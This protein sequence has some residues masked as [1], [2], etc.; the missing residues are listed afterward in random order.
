MT[1]TTRNSTRKAKTA[2]KGSK[3]PSVASK[4]APASKTTPKASGADTS[5]TVMKK[6]FCGVKGRSGAPRKNRN[7]IRHG[8]HAGQLPP[9][10]KYIEVRLNTFRRTVED[11]VLAVKGEIGITDAS[12]INTAVKWE[13]HG[14]LAQRWLRLEGDSLKPADRLNFSREIARASAERDRALSQLGL[15]EKPQLTLDTYLAGGSSE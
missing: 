15:D 8:L 7:G 2:A 6:R 5:E 3:R 4:P 13:R 14:M 12:Y 11:G 1:K 10:C 9:G